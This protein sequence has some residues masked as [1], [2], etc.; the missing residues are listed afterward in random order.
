MKLSRSRKMW[1]L[2]VVGV[3]LVLAQYQIASSWLV[4][5]QPMQTQTLPGHVQTVIDQLQLDDALVAAV[6]ER[7]LHD[8]ALQVSNL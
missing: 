5:S 4:T 6:G 8:I 3:C 7:V 2:M 1:L